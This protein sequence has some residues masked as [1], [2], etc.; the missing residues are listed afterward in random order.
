M[1]TK[2]N[3]IAIFT[4]ASKNYLAYVRVLLHS[5]AEIH[6]D[7]DLHL[8][9]ADEVDGAFDRSAERFQI[10]EAR[11]IGIPNFDYMAFTYDILEFNTAVKPFFIKFLFEK[12]YKKV[13]YFDP[14]IL[15]LNK[16]DDL[17]RLLDSCSLVLTPHMTAPLPPDDQHDPSELHMLRAGTYN[18][19]FIALSA[20]EET[21]AFY[22]WWC[23][24]CASSCY[25]ELETGLFVDQKWI[26]LAP[27]FFGSVHILRHKGYNMAYWNLHERTLAGLMVNGV[28]PLIFFHFSGI[29]PHDLNLLSKYQDRYKLDARKDLLALYE[30][31]KDLLMAKGYEQ[32]RQFSYHYGRYRN[33][34]AIGPADRRLYSL[35]AEEYPHPFADGPGSYYE[36]LK[37]R[38]LLEQTDA[39]IVVQR[40]AASNTGNTAFAK[41]VFIL[42]LKSLR[43]IL[44]MRIYR[45][46]MMHLHNISVIRKQ[47]FLIK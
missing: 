3:D 2:T 27:G 7:V 37:K 44:G 15:L 9:L 6:S 43:S 17:F 28:D 23:Q 19:G 42:F 10:A 14:D 30:R 25:A 39:S 45:T 40:G 11:E 13:I 32:T 33:G 20:A 18:L 22:T 29:V 26:N 41:R 36:L 46:L 8:L 35:V 24:K 1:I 47:D 5:I 12:G 34:V 21:T 4:I 16:L 38:R 31:Y